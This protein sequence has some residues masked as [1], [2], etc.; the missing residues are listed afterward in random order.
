MSYNKILNYW[1][2]NNNYNEFWFDKT[3]DK[4][5]KDNF[6]D[7]LNELEN[8]DSELYQNWNSSLKGKVAIIIVLETSKVIKKILKYLKTRSDLVKKKYTLQIQII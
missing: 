6:K 5:I 8:I 3:P 4:Y 2:P 7:I 1:F